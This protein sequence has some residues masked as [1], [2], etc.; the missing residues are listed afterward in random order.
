M[1]LLAVRGAR[2]VEREWKGLTPKPDV[3]SIFLG[4]GKKAMERGE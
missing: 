2:V 3:C 4:V 1:D